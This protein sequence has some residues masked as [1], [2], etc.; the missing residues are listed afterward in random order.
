MADTMLLIKMT[1]SSVTLDKKLLHFS[2]V[3]CSYFKVA[4]FKLN[5]IGLGFFSLSYYPYF[6]T[7]ILQIT[8]II[9]A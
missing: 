6:D 2:V 3:K 4:F 9:S 8:F 5:G 7:E 1:D